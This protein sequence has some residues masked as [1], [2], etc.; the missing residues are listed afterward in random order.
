MGIVYK[1]YD[2]TLERIV[3]LKILPDYLTSDRSAKERLY[4]EA[5][6]AAGLTHQNIAVV[7]EMGEHDGRVFIAMEYVEGK[8]LKKVLQEGSLSTGQ[9]LD[10]AIQVCEGIAAAHEKGIIHR[11]IKSENI[12][13]TRRGQPKITDFGLAKMKGAVSLTDT[14]TT[15]GTAAYMSPEQARGEQIDQRSD[16][17]SF[18]VVLYEMLAGRLPFKGEHE[19]AIIYSLMHE[20][21]EPLARY[22]ADVPHDLQTIVSK[23]LMKDKRERYQHIDEM[24]VDLTRISHQLP[25]ATVPRSSISPPR[26]ARLLIWAAAITVVVVL[27]AIYFLSARNRAVEKPALPPV[28][29]QIGTATWKDSIA[30]LPFKDY[31]AAKDQEYFCDGMTEDIITKLSRIHD[32][33]VISRSSTNGYKNTD[34]SAREIAKELGVGAILEGSI[35]K[36]KDQIRVNVQLVRAADDV[37][38]WA[39]NYDR[40]LEN[41]FEVQDQISIAIANALKF[42]LTPA[43]QQ[44]IA[45][46]YIDN[47]TAYEYYLKAGQEIDLYNRDGVARA[48]QYLQKGVDE[49]GDNA[50]LYT[51]MANA[52][53]QYVNIGIGQDEEIARSEEYLKKAL[54]LDPDLSEAH[55]ILGLI[56]ASILGNQGEAL[57]QCKLALDANPAGQDAL[58]ILRYLYLFYGKPSAAIPLISKLDQLDPR[59]WARFYRQG[60]LDYYTGE[61]ALA[62]KDLGKAYELDSSATNLQWFYF[63]SLAHT[64]NSDRAITM[65]DQSVSLTPNNAFSKEGIMLKYA[66]LK[67]TGNALRI[68]TPNV[69]KTFRRD[70][71]WSYHLATVFALLGMKKE[72]LDWLQNSVDRGFVNYILLQKDS[73]LDNIRSEA[74]FKELEQRVKNAWEHL[75]L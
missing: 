33:K 44:S 15:V 71:E 30:V 65:I 42:T 70:F 20:T 19:A 41:V 37:H 5:K 39:E 46:R 28:T 62:C 63:S 66:I 27:A 7:Y 22:T 67:D 45:K 60:M 32:L 38:L 73:F 26:T 13:L 69:W 6:A 49:I 50:L 31:S 72:S 48:L 59:I 2:L 40:R 74:R 17:F 51:A 61:Y 23:A 53:W 58:A 11:D 55:A 56:N 36:E 14:G 75:V 9:L 21:P 52:Y 34:K 12:I 3:A 24:T 1:A 54:A 29:P 18:G 64:G 47:I 25:S 43:E 35:Q 68:L 10:I 57:R 4:R 16:I 8:T